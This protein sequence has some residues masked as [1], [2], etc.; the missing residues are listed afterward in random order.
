MFVNILPV[1]S[2]IIMYMLTFCGCLLV[3]AVAYEQYCC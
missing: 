1:S 2:V 3:L